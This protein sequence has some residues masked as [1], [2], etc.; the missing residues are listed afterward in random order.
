M[1][2]FI[3][4]YWYT[5]YFYSVL[6]ARYTFPSHRLN[7]VPIALFFA[8][9][10]YFVTYHTLSNLILRKIETRSPDSLID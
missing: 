7:D 6:K 8:T 1:F 10:F 5:H 4:N 9:H 3:G 2:S